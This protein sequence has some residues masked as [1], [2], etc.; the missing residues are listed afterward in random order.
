MNYRQ[1]VKKFI[2]A[3]N[4]PIIHGETIICIWKNAS[5]LRDWSLS[6]NNETESVKIVRFSSEYGNTPLIGNEKPE[7][8]CIIVIGLGTPENYRDLRCIYHMIVKKSLGSIT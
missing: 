2:K 3:S 7:D 8:V 5:H 6:S 4:T 1:I